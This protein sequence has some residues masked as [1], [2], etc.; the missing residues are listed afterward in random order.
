MV[1][2]STA[3]S[4]AVVFETEA[5]GTTNQSSILIDLLTHSANRC[6]ISY[7]HTPAK[8]LYFIVKLFNELGRYSRYLDTLAIYLSLHKE[9]SYTEQHVRLMSQSVTSTLSCVPK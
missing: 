4:L 1:D 5:T 8:L 6:I 7:S 2:H 9:V 3:S